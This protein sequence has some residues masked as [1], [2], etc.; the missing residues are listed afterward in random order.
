MHKLH[1]PV[2]ISRSFCCADCDALSPLLRQ[3]RDCTSRTRLCWERHNA[4]TANTR[5]QSEGT[6]MLPHLVLRQPNA[7]L[8]VRKVRV[9]SQSE[10]PQRTHAFA[11]TYAN[12]DA[13]NS[14][15]QSIRTDAPPILI[16]SWLRMRVNGTR[17]YYYLSK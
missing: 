17:H 14:S 5:A 6:I 15:Q 13:H 8:Y 2:S 9:T 3:L 1:V 16:Y 11:F 7:Q 12:T 10:R 4:T